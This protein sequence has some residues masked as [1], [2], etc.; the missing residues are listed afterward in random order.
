MPKMFGLVYSHVEVSKKEPTDIIVRILFVT[1]KSTVTLLEDFDW[2]T[3]QKLNESQLNAVE[4][5]YELDEFS[6]LVENRKQ[7][8]FLRNI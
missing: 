1:G 7:F 6:L 5:G 8:S 2:L 3:V 4:E